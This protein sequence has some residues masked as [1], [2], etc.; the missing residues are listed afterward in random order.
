ML[1]SAGRYLF[2]NQPQVA[3]WNLSKLGRTF[4]DLMALPLDSKDLPLPEVQEGYTI[5]GTNLVEKMLNEF[6]VEF[7]NH[8][9]SLMRKKLGLSTERDSDFDLLIN[10]LLQIM[11][12]CRVDYTNFFRALCYLPEKDSDT[13]NIKGSVNHLKAAS[14]LPDCYSMLIDSLD[15]QVREEEFDFGEMQQESTL[16]NEFENGSEDQ[17]E[18]IFKQ[19][20]N[21]DIEILPQEDIDERWNEWLLNYRERVHLEGVK[22]DTRVYQM[23]KTNPKYTLRNWLLF[24]VGELVQKEIMYGG[25]ENQGGAILDRTLRIIVDDAFG[26]LSDL[27]PS[28]FSEESDK[29]FVMMCSGDGPAE[30][31]DISIK[32]N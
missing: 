7:N 23:R 20:V 21:K 15:N 25:G 18:V 30:L 2:A 19:F 16:S 4:T 17:L 31:I 27:D 11:T 26:L 14:S 12:D 6:E 9:A 24:E 32:T 28:G 3:L 5:S 22:D 10:P 29:N 1:D 13:D 8:Y